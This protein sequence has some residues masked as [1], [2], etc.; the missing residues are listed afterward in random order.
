MHLQRPHPPTHNQNTLQYPLVESGRICSNGFKFAEHCALP[1]CMKIRCSF[2]PGLDPA[3]LGSQSMK[4]DSK[5]GNELHR[6]DANVGLISPGDGDIAGHQV[7][8]GLQQVIFTPNHSRQQQSEVHH[9][10][11]CTTHHD[12][13]HNRGYMAPSFAS[14]LSERTRSSGHPRWIFISR[15]WP[16]LW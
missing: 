15:R 10:R 16:K 14:G 12:V 1:L 13:P 8:V 11:G 6:S 9:P 3:W 5:V 4:P 2:G 7:R